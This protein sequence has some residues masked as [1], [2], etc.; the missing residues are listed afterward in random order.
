[1][2]REK[3][4]D[5]IDDCEQNIYAKIFMFETLVIENCVFVFS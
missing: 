2:R 4:Y 3:Q 5:E 1:M